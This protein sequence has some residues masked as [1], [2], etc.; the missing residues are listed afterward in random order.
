[1]CCAARSRTASSQWAR[2]C[3]PRRNREGEI[4]DVLGVGAV[5]FPYRRNAQDENSHA[6]RFVEEAQAWFDSLWLTIAEQLRLDE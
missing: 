5:L 3:R 6:S 1:M 4:Y 2:A